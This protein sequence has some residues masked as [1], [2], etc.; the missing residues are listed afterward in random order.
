MVYLYVDPADRPPGPA[1]PDSYFLQV[2]GLAAGGST[3]FDRSITFTTIGCD[4]VI[5]VWVDKANHVGEADETNN[6]VSTAVCVGVT[7]QG[8]AIEPDNSCDGA[9]WQGTGS[10][11]SHTLCPMGDQDW[12]KFT[13]IGGMTY[14]LLAAN[15][16]VHADPVLALYGSCG[17]LS[18]F[19]TG[20]RIDWN[21]PAS[22]VY[23]LQVRHR[24]ATYGPLAGYDL[25]ISTHGSSG[26]V[27]E[28]DDSCAS[29]RD[30]PTTGA[31]AHHTFHAAGD[32]DWV[33]F[34]AGSGDSFSIVA[35]N[36][37]PGAQPRISLFTSCDQANGSPS[38]QGT[39]VQASAP[40]SQTYYA[41]VANQTATVYGPDVRYDLHVQSVS[42]SADSFE[43]D[44][45]TSVARSIAIGGAAQTHTSCPAGDA[46]WVKFT[47]QAGGIYAIRT[48]NLGPSADTNL[49]LFDSDGVTELARNDDYGYSQASRVFWLAPRAGVFYVQVRHHDPNASGADT[50]YD[51]S[52]T[53]GRCVVDPQEPDNGALD[54]RAIVTNGQPEDHNFCANA[55]QPNLGDQDWLRFDAVAGATYR[56]WTSDLGPD[57]DTA[58]EIYDRNGVSV[59]LTNDDRGS[60]QASDVNFVAPATGAYFIRILPYNA[61]LVGDGTEY[62]VAVQGAAPPTPTPSPT[63]T[64]T[65]TPTPRPTPSPAQVKTLILVNRQ[66]LAD[67][68]SPAEADAVLAKLYDLADHPRVQ[69]AVVQL[70][71]DPSVA[72]AYGE[73][74]ATQ[75]ALLSNDKANAV[76]S[77]IRNLVLNFLS[78]APNIEYIV[79]V[80]DD[81]AL[82]QR[83]VPQG[84]ISRLEHVYAPKA[85]AN[86]TLWAALQ[87][88]MILTDD[89]Y[90]D[91]E[92]T[93]RQGREFYI[94]DYALGRLIETPTEIEGVIDA[95]LADDTTEIQRALVTGYDFVSDT[96]TAVS[97]LLRNDNLTTDDALIGPVWS[98]D[99][100][101]QKQLQASPRFDFQSINGHAQHTAEGTPDQKDITASEV[102]TA[103]SDFAG[104]LVFSVGCHAGFNDSGTLDLAQA[105]ARVKANY[106]GN[107]GFGWGGS[108][109]VYSELLMKN[110]ARELLRDTS[111][112][113][114]KALV[115]AKRRYYQYQA[116]L[117]FTP[118][119][120]MV[121]MQ[122]TFYG[123]PMRMV[124]SGGTLNPEDPFPS[125][126]MTNTPPSAFGDISVGRIDFGLAGSF[127]AFDE[128]NTG[129][130]TFL[131]LNDSVDFSGG[132]PIQ[133][134]LFAAVPNAAAGT[135]HGALFLGGVYT[136]VTGFDP[137]IALP[138][139][140]YVT[141][142][143]EPDFSAPGWHP[144]VPFQ[145]RATDT[146]STQ[147]SAL[148]S[149][150]G[151]FDSASDTERVSTTCPSLP[152]SLPAPTRFQP[153][154]CTSTA[155]WWG[156]V[157]GNS[158]SKLPTRRAC[159]A[160]S[161]PT[162]TVRASGAART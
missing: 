145:V 77:A 105:F 58:I 90:G 55:S 34:G 152:C 140:E 126:V 5:Y 157:G 10:T 52:I 153:R 116:A 143:T 109:V 124:T 23:Y 150:L 17:G 75:E 144:A 3:S 147:A 146:I 38:A 78:T 20:P 84:N 155:C 93:V 46:D 114:G 136:D 96:G 95:F 103:T 70:E 118:Y 35:D 86:T 76:A 151:Q 27:Y 117:L 19:G 68:Y 108:G 9:Q 131:A 132:S 41:R 59:V 12:V 113:M 101:R 48:T 61:G 26:D 14:T 39:Q 33:K 91:K 42:C 6:L 73:W 102:V 83:R 139:N 127:G 98:G 111:A 53:Q 79:L 31:A 115:A 130:G 158:K 30:V 81:R 18:Q 161:W 88:D 8:D 28:P 85:T 129:D 54:A 149:V 51:L 156:A 97:G 160:W 64:P 159:P 137:V 141:D 15:L 67:L 104:A 24:Q 134:H 50:Q 72:S 100:L 112:S 37:G 62:Q 66:R 36:P 148:V 128:T 142:T 120:E 122:S 94:S 4:H 63:P 7:C 135:L 71:S 21:T 13:A 138:Y 29:A 2:P 125:V 92:P 22:G 69:G 154:C 121:L 57:S 45:T 49:T 40:T 107:T 106:V 65:P 87:A 43:E 110:F 56:I 60:G 16:G 99:S 162:P 123:L 82:P 11:K 80:G 47:A 133:P 119:D 44:D 74:T 25:S 32:E 1:T 89:Y